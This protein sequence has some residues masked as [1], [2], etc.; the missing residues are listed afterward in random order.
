MKNQS[1][2]QS[3]NS[4]V[5]KIQEP[6][7]GRLLREVSLDGPAELEAKIQAADL[8]HA[9]LKR[10]SR[11]RR[12]Q[13]I[14]QIAADLKVQA[15]EFALRICEEAAKPIDLA[16]VEVTRAIQN[17]E[18]AAGE[19]LRLGG[20]LLPLDRDPGF[21]GTLP[22]FS[23]RVARGPVLAISPF[24]F[25]LNLAV[26][27]VAPALAVGASVLLKP[28]PQAP[29]CALLLEKL[30]EGARKKVAAQELPEKAFQ[31]TCAEPEVLRAALTD[32]RL[33]ILSFTGSDRTGEILGQ[34]ARH[35]KLLM[36]LGGN[37]A[38]CVD[39]DADLEWAAA[40]CAWGAY[41]YAGQICISVQ[42]I[43]VHQKIA[44]LFT[45]RL[46]EKISQLKIGSP[47]ETGVELSSLINDSAASRILGWITHAKTQGAKILAG[48]KL[49]H[50]GL[51]NLLLPTLLSGVPSGSPL[52]EEEVFGP[53]AVL[54]EVNSPQEAIAAINASRF[55]LQ[56]GIFSRKLE[57]LSWG[58][59]EI[60]A[61]GIWLNDV[62]T[63]R[64]DSLPYG[65]F[66][67]SGTGREGVRFAMEEFS[68]W[69]T[70]MVRRTSG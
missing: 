30:V 4:Q 16:R 63:V 14:L 15:E 27:K 61:G 19:T 5:W 54:V 58:M 42:R 24:N 10:T 28:P 57:A 45:E 23:Q 52:L 50:G 62:P 69:K 38:V 21:S 37:A 20:E 35:K 70:L 53:V 56:A 12:S 41:V 3:P 1:P 47:L 67:D 48:G 66:K 18:L 22:A 29:S 65:G 44:A 32:P 51:K 46:L 36:E 55:G 40:R 39:E 17:F 33:R 6:Q 9:Q 11:A 13:W 7:T 64:V 34:L 43:Y 25:P 8:A 59:Q 26:H 68:E 2:P 60:D 31:V 49:S